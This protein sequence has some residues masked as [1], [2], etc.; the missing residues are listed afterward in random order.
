MADT[1]TPWG[2]RDI[3]NH[4]GVS[5]QRADQLARQHGFPMPVGRINSSKSYFG[6]P[7]WN[8]ETVK[9]WALH[10]MLTNPY[11]QGEMNATSKR[12]TG[13]PLV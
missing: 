7:V 1:F 5:R 9:V 4:L 10:R 2:T 8:A 6:V 3:A 13:R 12:I 11:L